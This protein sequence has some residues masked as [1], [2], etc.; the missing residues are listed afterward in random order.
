MNDQAKKVLSRLQNLCAKQECCSGDMMT[1]AVK[2]LDGDRGQA[3]EVV[4]ALIK[5]KPRL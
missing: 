5:E 3:A 1:K 4:E 2:A